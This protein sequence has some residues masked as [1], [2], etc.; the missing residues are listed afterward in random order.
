MPR[1][2]RIEGGYQLTFGSQPVT[3]P[4]S[5]PVMRD[6]ARFIG[7][8]AAEWAPSGLSQISETSSSSS[9]IE[10][11]IRVQATRARTTK[12]TPAVARVLGFI[13]SADASARAQ[14]VAAIPERR[15]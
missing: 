7:T 2:S 11:L 3:F 8:S 15:R 4:W 10:R 6:P 1:P 13:P 9:K 12:V 5:E 14:A